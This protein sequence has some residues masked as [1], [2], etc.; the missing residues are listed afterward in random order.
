MIRYVIT[1]SAH[2]L[3]FAEVINRQLDRCNNHCSLRCW[4][5]ASPQSTHAFKFVDLLEAAE[6]AQF[7][8]ALAVHLH[9]HL[10]HIGGICYSR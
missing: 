10:K 3:Q 9:A 2:Q 8:G 5:D 1:E 6:Q 7:I 4:P